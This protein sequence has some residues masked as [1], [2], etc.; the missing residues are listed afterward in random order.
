MADDAVTEAG[1]EPLDLGEDRRS[2]VAAVAVGDMRVGPHRVGVADG[3]P[4]VGEILLADQHEWPLGHPPGV[5]VAFGRSQFGERADDVHG[6]GA[7]GFGIGP[8]DTAFDGEVDLESTGAPA[9]SVVRTCYSAWEPI[10]E[11]SG[12][13]VRCQIE[14]GHVGRRKL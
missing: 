10:R 13:R 8:R 7:T 5:D 1:C 3:P 9:E 2:G 11:D 12:Y 14:H 6:P 4:W